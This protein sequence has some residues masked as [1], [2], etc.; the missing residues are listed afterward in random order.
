[1]SL[2]GLSVGFVS[3]LESM[4]RAALNSHSLDGDDDPLVRPAIGVGSGE[5]RWIEHG[6]TAFAVVIVG[7]LLGLGL[8]NVVMYSRWHDVE[9]GVLWG[10]RPE[11]LTA[12]EVARGSA[13]PRPA[14]SAT[15]C[16][17]P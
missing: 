6:R 16:S 2:A 14:S 17:L 15:T 9:D 7:V 4:Q 1:M 10:A 12:L 11:G 3:V 13:G 5:R 8:A